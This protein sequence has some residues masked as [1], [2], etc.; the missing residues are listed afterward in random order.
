MN[1]HLAKAETLL[2]LHRREQAL[3]E[4][5][6]ALA[7]EPQNADC[8]ALMG[9]CLAQ[10][11][12]HQ[13]GLAAAK[14]ALQLAPE[15]AYPH[16]ALALIH[17]ARKRWRRA[18]RAILEAIRLEPRDPRHYEV[19]ANIRLQ[20]NDARRA[21]IAATRGLNLDPTHLGCMLEQA[22]AL[23]QYGK[24][25]KALQVLER[26]LQQNPTCG[27]PHYLLGLAHKNMPT[28]SPEE[29][30]FHRQQA[31]AHFLEAMRLEPEGEYSGQELREAVTNHLQTKV[32]LTV[33]GTLFLLGTIAGV[34]SI[35]KIRIGLPYILLTLFWSLLML[36][37]LLFLPTAKFALL[38]RSLYAPKLLTTLERQLGRILEF[39]AWWMLAVFLLL[40]HV[41]TKSLLC[42][43]FMIWPVLFTW[44]LGRR[45]RGW[46]GFSWR[47]LC[48]TYLCL[49][50]GWV[51]VVVQQ[52]R[53]AESFSIV[54]ITTTLCLFALS[55][56]Q[57]YRAW[58][59]QQL[60]N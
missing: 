3:Q 29:E 39:C 50:V 41:E 28:Q 38:H 31:N 25:R 33:V 2:D 40:A 9:I 20:I 4:L 48:L 19:L 45:Y 11:G 7:L 16:F 53:M 8:H 6:K 59:Q 58:H 18:R 55:T 24:G 36:L 52:D 56:F 60:R 42:L 1:P 46:K 26:A 13:A 12:R 44:F 21:F 23:L 17:R 54:M 57:L 22:R 14:Q 30:R 15:S 43:G 32:L 35:Y 37:C 51:W 49:S 10:A 27:Y 5:E 34:L 47:L